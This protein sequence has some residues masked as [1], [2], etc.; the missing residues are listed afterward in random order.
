MGNLIKGLTKIEIESACPCA[1]TDAVIKCKQLIKL[2]AVD[3]DL[4][5]PC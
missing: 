4:T 1:L 3:F 5:K 2:V